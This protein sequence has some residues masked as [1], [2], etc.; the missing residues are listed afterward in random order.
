MI[1]KKSAEEI[2]ILKEAGG[3]LGTIL[4]T[5]GESLK[6]GMSTL[7]VDD[8]AMEL[9]EKYQVEPVLLGY[10][11]TFADFP[12]PAAI[13]VSVNDCVQH[14]VPSEDVILKKGDTVNLDM[15][16]AH[17]GM[18]VDSGITVPVGE[19]SDEARRLI[20][21]TKEALALG[22]KQAKPGN[23]I[24]DISHAIQTLVEAR[25][26]SVVE[27]LCGH[28]VGYAVHEEPTIPNFGK[29][30]TGPLIEAGH[31]YAIEPIVNIGS[32]D[33]FFD[34]EGDGYSVYTEDGSWSA[35]FEHT[36]AITENGPL[37]LTKS[38]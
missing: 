30:G 38:Q 13:C 5:L 20:E 9:V 25:G 22:I 29:P 12:Y 32:A 4:R 14:G 28:G 7:D 17:K 6:P 34:D 24:G 10:H 18:I 35:H 8:M 11:P 15:S 2:E 31:V 33:V 19:I 36:V 3:I 16:I 1:T 37:I 23:H 21:V 26:F 27:V